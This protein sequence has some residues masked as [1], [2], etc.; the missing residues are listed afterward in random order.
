MADD[1]IVVSLQ[2]KI[3]GITSH[4]RLEFNV[5][6]FRSL[7]GPGVYL[8]YNKYKCL[9]VG[10]SKNILNRVSNEK[11]NSA[12]Q[13]LREATRIEIIPAW[14]LERARDIEAFYIAS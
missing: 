9:Y 5:N 3:F 11:H 7:V 4:L 12:R 8:I 1:T 10:H 14:S 13:A 6:D 2:Q